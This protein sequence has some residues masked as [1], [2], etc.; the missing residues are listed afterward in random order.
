MRGAQSNQSKLFP[1]MKHCG[2]PQ[3]KRLGVAG[4]LAVKG[5]ELSSKLQSVLTSSDS[6]DDDIADA[7]A[8]MTRIP[9]VTLV[10]T[11]PPAIVTTGK[12][13]PA[14]TGVYSTKYLPKRSHGERECKTEGIERRVRHMMSLAWKKQAISANNHRIS[15][16]GIYT[17]GSTTY[18]GHYCRRGGDSI[19]R[20]SE[21]DYDHGLRRPHACRSAG[22]AEGARRFALRPDRVAIE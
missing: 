6:K 22:E 8:G 19:A 7:M 2:L 21:L 17:S 11:S 18:N 3:T 12:Y 20:A 13:L 5:S 1:V 10:E 4:P 9:P 14:T 15:H 16:V